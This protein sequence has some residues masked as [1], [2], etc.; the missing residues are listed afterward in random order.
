LLLFLQ[1]AGGD[2][3]I[4]SLSIDRYPNFLL[5]APFAIRPKSL[6]FD[7]CLGDLF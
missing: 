2:V 7:E 1:E 4:S 3:V 5:G 6:A